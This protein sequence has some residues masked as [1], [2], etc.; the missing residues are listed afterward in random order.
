MKPHGGHSNMQITQSFTK[1]AE[2]TV[3]L[4]KVNKGQQ[5]NHKLTRHHSRHYC[6]RLGHHV[7]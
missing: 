6:G 3:T 7:N 5:S 2:V 4:R 1:K